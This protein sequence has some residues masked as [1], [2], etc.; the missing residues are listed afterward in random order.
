MYKQNVV[1]CNKSKY[2]KAS[3]ELLDQVFSAEHNYISNDSNQWLCCACDSALSHGNM[4]VQVRWDIYSTVHFEYPWTETDII[5]GSIYKNG[6]ITF[7][8]AKVCSKIAFTVR[9]NCSQTEA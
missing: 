6:S 3:N 9:T 7:W 1:P 2:T 8:Q 5:K 4:A